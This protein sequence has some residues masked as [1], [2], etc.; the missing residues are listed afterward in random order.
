MTKTEL[1][2]YVAMVRVYVMD[3]RNGNLTEALEALDRIEKG[4]EEGRNE[5]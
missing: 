2:E 1:K 4:I 3:R 5:R